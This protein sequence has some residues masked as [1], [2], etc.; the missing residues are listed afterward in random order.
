M[1]TTAPSLMSRVF[2]SQ[3]EIFTPRQRGDTVD[4]VATV[5][6]C[7]SRKTGKTYLRHLLCGD[8]RR[9]V[10]SKTVY[11]PSIGMVGPSD[12]VSVAGKQFKVVEFGGELLLSSY[13]DATL[14]TLNENLAA[15][16]KN[17]THVICVVRNEREE[18]KWMKVLSTHKHPTGAQRIIFIDKENVFEGETFK[19]NGRGSLLKA[20]FDDIDYLVS[21][22]GGSTT[23]VDA[24]NVPMTPIPPDDARHSDIDIIEPDEADRAGL[25]APANSDGYDSDTS[26]EY[27]AL[28]DLLLAQDKKY[29]AE[30][31]R[32][33]HFLGV[34][35]MASSYK[36]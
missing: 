29:E 32:K 12:V 15:A 22:D 14:Q 35:S 20:V 30:T 21:E 1:H 26:T 16:I 27:M 5:T 34:S 6:I 31:R 19:H 10:M 18:R 17:S 33:Q 13:D 4:P 2:G 28:A 8:Y 24:G 25:P 36:H 23:Y 7:G 9:A 11:A 3:S